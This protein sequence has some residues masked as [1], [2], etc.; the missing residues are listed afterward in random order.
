MTA[1]SSSTMQPFLAVK[2]RTCICE[3]EPFDSSRSS[4]FPALTGGRTGGGDALEGPSLD[5][6]PDG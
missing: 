2:L 1:S 5:N 3:F 4:I 6:W